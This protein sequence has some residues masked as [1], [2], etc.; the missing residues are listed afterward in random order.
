L[1][2]STLHGENPSRVFPVL[3]GLSGLLECVAGI[4]DGLANRKRETHGS[5]RLFRAQETADGADSEPLAQQPKSLE[6]VRLK[7]V[8][9]KYPSNVRRGGLSKQRNVDNVHD[10]DKRFVYFSR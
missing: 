10:F 6:E 2:A 4:S 7:L 1:V 5:C 8:V 9:I 3:G